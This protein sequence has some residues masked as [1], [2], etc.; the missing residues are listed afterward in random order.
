MKF[1]LKT[2]NDVLFRAVG[3]GGERVIEWRDPAGKWQP[4]TGHQLYGRVRAFATA[5]AGLGIGKGDRVAI[6]AENRWEWAVADFA[7]LALGAVD[8]PLYST[9]TAQQV[10]G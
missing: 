6:L 1:D 5:L 9:L 2:I 10:A 7:V 3:A 8:V 4:I